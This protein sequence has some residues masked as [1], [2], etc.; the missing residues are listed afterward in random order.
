M[1]YNKNIARFR[2]ISRNTYLKLLLKIF[3]LILLQ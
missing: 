2:A 1:K 3:I